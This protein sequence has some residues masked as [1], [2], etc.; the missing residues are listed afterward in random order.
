MTGESR[1]ERDR[2]ISR[3][4]ETLDTRH[5]GQLDVKGFQR[6]LKRMDH[7][8]CLPDR[9]FPQ[10]GNGELRLLLTALFS[11]EKCRWTFTRDTRSSRYKRRRENP[12]QR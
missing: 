1:S 8:E 10:T 5:E 3:L 6:G 2:R 4:W 12:V 7:R 9:N 11:S